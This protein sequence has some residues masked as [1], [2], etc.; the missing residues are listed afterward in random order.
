M[1]ETPTPRILNPTSASNTAVLGGRGRELVAAFERRR[2]TVG[3]V[4][5]AEKAGGQTR[6]TDEKQR[7]L[8]KHLDNVHDLVEDLKEGGGLFGG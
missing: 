1:P 3:G 2:E 4:E 7:L 5:G 8:G 6:T